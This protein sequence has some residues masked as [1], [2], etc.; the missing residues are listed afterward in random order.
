MS[1]NIEPSEIVPDGVDLETIRDRQS[2]V[3]T[4][5]RMCCPNPD[6]IESQD[7]GS[8]AVSPIV[9][10]ITTD[11]APSEDYRCDHCGNRFEEPD[12]VVIEEDSSE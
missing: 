1:Q 10:G 3:S 6:C 5:E 11:P 12:T 9:P 2:K 7:H 8:L 4:G